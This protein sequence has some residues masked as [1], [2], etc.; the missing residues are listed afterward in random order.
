MELE[1]GLL[2]DEK[3]CAEHV[4]LVDLGRNDVGKVGRLQHEGW[5]WMRGCVG[6]RVAVRGVTRCVERVGSRAAHVRLLVG[7]TLFA[8]FVSV[9][10]LERPLHV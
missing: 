5:C 3:E 10:P 7:C 4:M 2:A 9:L 6:L 8:T 1:R